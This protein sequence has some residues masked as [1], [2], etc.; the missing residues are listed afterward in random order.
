MKV[1]DLL[2]ATM[3]HARIDHNEH[4]TGLLFMVSAAV[5]DVAHE[6]DYTLPPAA[7]DL[8]DDLRLAIID[9]AAMLYDARG[10]ETDRPLGLSMA[11][12]R[13]LAKY[14]AVRPRGMCHRQFRGRTSL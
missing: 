14:C 8:P 10:G 2:T 12:A 9:Q 13:I 11:A 6:A 4:D 5:A 1:S 3:L 7:D